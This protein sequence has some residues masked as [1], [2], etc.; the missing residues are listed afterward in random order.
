MK[1]HSE[2]EGSIFYDTM[3]LSSFFRHCETDFFRIFFI[4]PPI[5]FWY[6]ATESMF[7]KSQSVPPF[8]FFGTKR[9]TGNFK[10]IPKKFGIFFSQFLVFRVFVV[11]SCK[12]WFSSFWALDMEPWAVPGLLSLCWLC[13]CRA[14]VGAKCSSGGVC[15]SRRTWCTTRSSPA[16]SSCCRSCRWCSWP[17]ASRPSTTSSTSPPSETPSGSPTRNLS[18]YSSP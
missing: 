17:S 1:S 4:V 18:T 10:K 6:F 11:S 12:K 14:S 15:V 16:S 7:K 5:N 2:A 13:C 9:L 8:T 3:R